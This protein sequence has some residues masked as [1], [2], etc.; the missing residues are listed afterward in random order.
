MFT[1]YGATCEIHGMHRP[2]IH[3]SY[4]IEQL[5]A[6]LYLYTTM[7]DEDKLY[8]RHLREREKHRNESAEQKAIK[9]QVARPLA[10]PVSPLNFTKPICVL[11][12]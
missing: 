1:S 6:I 2:G 9:L 4:A 8:A 3:S 5:L 11:A 12:L 10:W 7:E